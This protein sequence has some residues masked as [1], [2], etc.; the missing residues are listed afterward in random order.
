MTNALAI[1]IAWMHTPSR[2]KD[3]EKLITIAK[4]VS[5]LRTAA[6]QIVCCDIMSLFEMITFSN[7]YNNNN[8]N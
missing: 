3:H 7:V 1:K 6:I 5:E 4:S 8:N 2:R